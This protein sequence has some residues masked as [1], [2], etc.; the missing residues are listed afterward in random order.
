MYV[1]I[2]LK[3]TSDFQGNHLSV[4]QFPSSNGCSA[5]SEHTQAPK[6]K[7]LLTARCKKH[8]PE[9]CCPIPWGN[10][11]LRAVEVKDLQNPVLESGCKW[12]SL[13][14]ET[15]LGH[16]GP[17]MAQGFLGTE[18]EVWDFGARLLVFALQ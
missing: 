10:L 3:E 1:L 11:R 15:L 2:Y 6:D 16:R 9:S 12:W 18:G 4:L 13:A 14:W 5:G 7:P 17:G 8:H